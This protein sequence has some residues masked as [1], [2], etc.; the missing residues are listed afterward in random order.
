MDDLS[1]YG[2]I[3]A[4]CP[5]FSGMDPETAARSVE[6]MKGNIRSYRR[7]G[8]VHQPWTPLGRFGMVLSGHVQAC[9][10]DYDGNRMIM[11]EVQPG[12]T[13]GESLCFLHIDDSPVYI[14]ASVDSEVLWLSV[15]E[16]Y[17]GNA[18][19]LTAELQKRFTTL[20]ASR[21]LAMNDRI[22]IL[23]RKT[24]REKLTV[25]FSELS[26]RAGS[27]AFQVPFTREDMAAYIGTDRASLSRALSAM[28]RDGLIGY[29]G[30]SFRLLRKN[31]I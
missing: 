16:L 1:R 13:F 30:K 19:G 27:D 14:R 26:S 8:T 6:L 17:G 23:S 7:G 20:L 25:Y 29:R 12:V 11:A 21:T 5:L 15:Q 3:L 31:E 2:K 18:D 4:A 22:Q 28:Q 24:I 9:C 10:D